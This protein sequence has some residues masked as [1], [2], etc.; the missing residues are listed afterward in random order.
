VVAHACNFRFGRWRQED[1]QFEASLGYIARLCLKKLNKK[2][3]SVTNT[4]QSY[5][6]VI[7]P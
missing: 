3:V 2:I 7:I 5:F 6:L 4:Y 1:L